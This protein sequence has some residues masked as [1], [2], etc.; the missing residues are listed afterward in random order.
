MTVVNN[1]T[2]GTF[3]LSA[4]R[5]LV[6]SRL[7]EARA[8]FIDYLNNA[9]IA[10]IPNISNIMTIVNNI[11]DETFGL[12]ALKALV[13][14]QKAVVDKVKL[15]FTD[16][17]MFTQSVINDWLDKIQIYQ[18]TPANITALISKYV[19]TVDG[20]SDFGDGVET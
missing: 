4:I 9:N 8:G 15:G 13:D 19:P 2:D 11:T 6:N 16:L 7:T 10:T 18:D 1:I 17:G 14:L 20:W 5:N 12:S 3:G